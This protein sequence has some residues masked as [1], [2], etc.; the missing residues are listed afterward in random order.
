MDTVPMAYI[1]R[2]ERTYAMT[3]GVFMQSNWGGLWFRTLIDTSD[4]TGKCCHWLPSETSAVL[5]EQNEV[6]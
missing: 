5:L 1:S 4:Q 3:S 6:G 2:L